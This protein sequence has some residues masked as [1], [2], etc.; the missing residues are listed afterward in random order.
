MGFGPI[1]LTAPFLARRHPVTDET[2]ADPSGL[3]EVEARF[4][5]AG[6][7]A[8]AADMGSGID[9]P[10]SCS[11]VVA[12]FDLTA[13]VDSRLTALPLFSPCLARTEATVSISIFLAR[14][15][16]GAMSEVG[17]QQ[18]TLARHELVVGVSETRQAAG[19]RMLLARI[20]PP[21]AAG[22]AMEFVITFTATAG[23]G[24]AI[25]AGDMRIT[26]TLTSIT[27]AGA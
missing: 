18:T 19:R 22:D 1:T 6:D 7:E 23:G 25:A 20:D 9:L 21:A 13:I 11:L 15:V 12:L 27:V 3:F 10:A 17:F 4:A 5:V 14:A 24:G 2:I 16:T 26:G 8:S